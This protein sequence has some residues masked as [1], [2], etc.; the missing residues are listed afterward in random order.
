MLESAQHTKKID[1]NYYVINH[2]WFRGDILF[3]V[4]CRT[5]I[6][7]SYLYRHLLANLSLIIKGALMQIWKSCYTF[8]FISKQYPENFAFL[9]LRILELSARDVCYFLK[10][11]LIYNIYYSFWMFVNKLFAYLTCAYLKKWKVF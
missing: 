6:R 8:V 9:I 10:S 5:Q 4:I 3:C 1:L 2:Q 11:R 7:R